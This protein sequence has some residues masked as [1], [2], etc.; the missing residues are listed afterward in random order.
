MRCAARSSCSARGAL[1]MRAYSQPMPSSGAC[2][3]GNMCDAVRYA[4]I[5]CA[6]TPYL[7]GATRCPARCTCARARSLCP[8]AARAAPG[9]V[10][11][12]PVR[13]H[14][15]RAETL[16]QRCHSLPCRLRHT[17]GPF[18]SDVKLLVSVF[19]EQHCKQRCPHALAVTAVPAWN[20]SMPWALPEHHPQS[21]TEELTR[22]NFLAASYLVTLVL[23][24]KGV[25]KPEP[26]GR[27]GRARWP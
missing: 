9:T 7:S 2:S 1:F 4:A 20:Y 16:S 18:K 19:Q 5:A 25:P 23:G 22:M 14:R 13:R 27:V 17:R 6:Q 11:R 12:G 3:P 26:G 10:R 24:G 8:A 15:L 21:I